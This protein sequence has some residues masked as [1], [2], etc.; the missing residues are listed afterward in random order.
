MLESLHVEGRYIMDKSGVPVMFVGCTEAQTAW[1][2]P[3]A[4]NTPP[5]WSHASDPIPMA[6]SMAELGVKWVRIFISYEFWVDPTI[7][8]SYRDL[9]DRYIQEFT[10]RNV[11][12]I[13]TLGMPQSFTDADQAVWLALLTEVA[14]RYIS[15]AGM[16]GISL[17]N[18][19]QSDVNTWRAWARLGA[20]AVHAANPNLLILVHSLSGYPRYVDGD[21]WRQNPIGVPN[22][23]WVYHNYF[24][25]CYYYDKENFA[26]NYE[27]GNYAL[28][29]Q[30][31]EAYFYDRYFKWAVEYGM[32]IMNEEFGFNDN[33]GATPADKGYSPGFPQCMHDYLQLH[34]KYSIPWNEYAWHMGGYGLTDDGVTLNTVGEIWFEYLT[35]S[36]PIS[37]LKVAGIWLVI[38][39]GAGT[40][41]KLTKRRE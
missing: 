14:N 40:A 31:M 1:S 12:C 3:T 25:Q 23:V 26:L 15:N 20:A 7:G 8:A 30:Q 35:L 22:V 24:W 33:T 41:L 18:E 19:P 10:T 36:P 28:A 13:V 9:I 6:E 17:F 27:A 39:I 37:L 16:C 11:Y 5:W 32:C 34:N 38:F 29:K 4:P 21:Y 2:Y